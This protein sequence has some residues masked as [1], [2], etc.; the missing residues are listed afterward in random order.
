MD[1]L[2]MLVQLVGG[3][4]ETVRRLRTAGF[5]KAKDLARADVDD[6]RAESDLSSA[7]SRQLVSAAK[8][9]LAPRRERRALRNGLRGV[10]S[11]LAGG[12]GSG[13][14]Q[15]EA[16]QG[17]SAGSGPKPRSPV[18]ADQGVSKAESSALLGG[19]ARIRQSF[20]RFG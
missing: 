20:W 8:E 14:K 1:E 19:E 3:D 18:A 17:A 9:M 2:T 11:A 5:R 16:R 10:P 4:P 15:R 7:A 12:E 6:L 13:K